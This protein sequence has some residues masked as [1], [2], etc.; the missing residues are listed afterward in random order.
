M[1]YT[2]TP[3]HEPMHNDQNVV[4]PQLRETQTT[5]QSYYV[6]IARFTK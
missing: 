2:Q 6:K 3:K 5:T 1:L 4:I